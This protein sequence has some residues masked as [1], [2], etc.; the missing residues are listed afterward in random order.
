MYEI[1]FLS[2][3]HHISHRSSF[4][5]DIMERNGVQS[6]DW[7]INTKV[8]RLYYCNLNMSNL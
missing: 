7:N 8:G 2:Y 1:K 4:V 6:D 5:F 3:V